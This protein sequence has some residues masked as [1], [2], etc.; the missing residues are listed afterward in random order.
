MYINFIAKFEY[1]QAIVLKDKEKKIASDMKI[2]ILVEGE[3]LSANVKKE[4]RIQQPMIN[5]IN[6]AQNKTCN[7]A[8]IAEYWFKLEDQMPLN[9]SAQVM[10]LIAKRQNQ[11]LCQV[12]LTAYF[13]DP[14][15]DKSIKSH[16]VAIERCVNKKIKDIETLKA[17]AEY[18]EKR[19]HFVDIAVKLRTSKT[20]SMHYN[21]NRDRKSFL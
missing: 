10:E 5:L 11:A 17:F 8:T 13:F 6:V 7:L 12:T 18:K 21:R 4:I 15:K 20:L 9:C 14:T 3:K 2:Q 1:Y 19:Q 16:K